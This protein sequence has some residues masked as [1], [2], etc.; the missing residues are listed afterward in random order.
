MGWPRTWPGC[1]RRQRRRGVDRSTWTPPP[2]FGLVAELGRVPVADL[3]R[4]LNLGVGIVAVVRPGRGDAAV[5]RLDAR[6]LPAWV[7]G[8]VA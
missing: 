7:L 5:A 3:E 4:T 8:E 2:I 1:C 6:G